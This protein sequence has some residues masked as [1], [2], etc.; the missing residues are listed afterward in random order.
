MTTN[1]PMTRDGILPEMDENSLLAEI[2]SGI[3]KM[4]QQMQSTYSDLGQTTIS[5]FSKDQT[6]EIIM[7]ATYELRDINF[8]PRAFADDNG[9]FSQ[10]ELK[11]RLVEA[12]KDL[13]VKIQ[14][15][16]QAKTLELLKGMDIPD[17]LKNISLPKE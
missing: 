6:V 16:T 17:D 15:T 7:T 3:M 5:G 11:R 1:M 14:Q 8:T 10:T 4:Q 13:G 9:K 2:K 12:W